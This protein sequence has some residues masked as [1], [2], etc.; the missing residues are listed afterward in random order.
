MRAIAIE[1]Y[2]DADCLRQMAIPRPEPGRG[3]L[4]LKVVSAGVSPVDALIRSGALAE[5]IPGTFPL[6]PG[7]DAAG[8]VEEFGP[9]AGRFRKGDRVWACARKPAAQWGCYAEYVAVSEDAVGSMPARLLFEEAAAVPLCALA[10]YQ[11]IVVEPAVEQGQTV[12]IHGAAGGVGHFAVQLAK[13]QGGRVLASAST[14]N[15]SFVLGLGA[16]AGI[17]T[18]AEGVNE[19]ALRHAPEGVDL[20]LDLVGGEQ[21]ELLYETVRPGGRLISLAAEPDKARCEAGGITGEARFVEPNGSQLERIARH[22]DNHTLKPHVQKIYPL[23]KAAEAHRALEEGQV[24]GK[25]VLNL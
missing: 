24:R 12:L 21:L 17:D 4:L 11:C 23:A 15:Q 16:A 1:S 9:G 20:A 2:G 13:L 5:H 22:F 25:L 8:V 7:W 3:E 19:A 18:S 14:E 6:I 10:A